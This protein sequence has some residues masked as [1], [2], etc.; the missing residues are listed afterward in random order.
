VPA[1]TDVIQSTT[2]VAS[3]V[4]ALLALREA[5][6]QRRDVTVA[7]P[8]PAAPAVPARQPH[9]PPAPGEPSR[10]DAPLRGALF[11]FVYGGVIGALVTLIGFEVGG[12]TSQIIASVT[13]L[14]V[15]LA[16]LLYIRFRG[17]PQRSERLVYA[18]IVTA[19]GSVGA[20]IVGLLT[21]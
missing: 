9:H 2:A 10:E 6:L 5:R 13:V 21:D 20:L 3:V 12:A 7:S 1:T 15:M 11:T 18:L 8:R 17:A 16:I 19:A 14:A 4:I